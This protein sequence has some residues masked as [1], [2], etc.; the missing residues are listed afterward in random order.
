MNYALAARQMRSSYDDT[1]GIADELF[2]QDSQISIQ[3][4]ELNECPKRAQLPSL[5]NF[6]RNAWAEIRFGVMSTIGTRLSADLAELI[7]DQALEVEEIPRDPRTHNPYDYSDYRDMFKIR[8]RP[9][10]M[11]DH[12]EYD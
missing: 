9:E 7:F 10:Y 3:S 4:D 2:D 8:P 1:D 11:C 6:Y 12:G 5:E